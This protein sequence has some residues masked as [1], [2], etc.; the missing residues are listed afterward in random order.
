M[1][2]RE[3]PALPG[4]RLLDPDPHSPLPLPRTEEEG[5]SP[6]LSEAVWLALMLLLIGL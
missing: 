5:A 3:A 1:G 6:A 4:R 2:E